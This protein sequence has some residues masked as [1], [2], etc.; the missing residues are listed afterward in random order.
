MRIFNDLLQLHD[1]S[2]STV[3]VPAKFSGSGCATL[4]VRSSP[5][6]FYVVKIKNPILHSQFLSV[7]Y[8]TFFN[9]PTLYLGVYIFDFNLPLPRGGGE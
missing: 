2:F 8:E 3:P 1:R 7:R 6:H 9:V 5:S 4:V